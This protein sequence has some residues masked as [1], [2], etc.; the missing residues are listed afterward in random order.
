[1]KNQKKS[2]SFVSVA[3]ISTVGLI[4]TRI[5][6]VV[7][8]IPFAAMTLGTPAA[9]VNAYAYTMFQPFYE[10]SLAGLPLAIARLISM[11]NGNGK[12]HTSNKVLH[13]A[14]KILLGLGLSLS[15]LFILFA[16]PFSSLKAGN[17]PQ[18]MYSIIYALIIIAPSLIL[19]P[20]M[21]SIRGYLQGFKTV[22]G[23]SVSQVV[24]RIAYV[25][26][27]LIILY[28]SMYRWNIESGRSMTFAFIALPLASLITLISLLPFYFQTRRHHQ[29]LMK[30]TPDEDIPS[31]KKI[32][33]QIIFTALPF[34]ISGL[35]STLY[36]QITLF[37]YQGVRVFARVAPAL[38]EFEFTII[39]QWS[40]K[41][42]SIPLTFSLAISVAIISF[43]TSSYE[44]GDL[45]QTQKHV[46]KAYRMIIFTT[47]TSVILMALFAVPLV[48][49]FYQQELEQTLFIARVL[50]FDGFRGMSFA[51]ETIVISLLLALGQKRKALIYSCIGPL[52][53]L[54]LNIPLVLLLGIYGDIMA[55]MLGLLLIV[56]LCTKDILRITKLR[57]QF[58]YMAFIKTIICTM[59]SILCIFLTN[60]LIWT[61]YPHIFSSRLLSLIYLAIVGLVNLA[62]IGGIAHKINFLRTVFRH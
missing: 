2:E 36:S 15:L 60:S 61:I 16:Y 46:K 24:E 45:R 34:V 57:L 3:L 18:F 19:I 22:I 14:Q 42:V 5:I 29:E 20:M 27:L 48:T 49:F 41:L 59:P 21:S 51:L 23:V 28:F 37:M 44:S 25:S 62:I 38:A 55:T 8:L 58:I 33:S 56:C 31:D 17:D 9:A 10:L 52:L 13:I 11:Y 54:L 43:V 39:N 32:L 1:M 6:S 7:Y 47:L 26:I 53:K 30:H 35:A 50:R 12:Y 4:T 40:D